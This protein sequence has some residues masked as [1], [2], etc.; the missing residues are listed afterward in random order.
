M[1]RLRVR[2]ELGEC[3]AVVCLS[4]CDL[5]ENEVDGKE[6]RESSINLYD[7]RSK[8]IKNEL[9]VNFIRQSAR[10][11]TENLYLYPVPCLK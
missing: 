10:H 5:L 1:P 9:S 11:G 2:T 4:G 6:I 7:I 8:F 3:C